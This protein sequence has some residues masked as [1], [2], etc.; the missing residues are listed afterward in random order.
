MSD[1][2]SPE[3]LSRTEPLAFYGYAHAAPGQHGALLDRM[4]E[5]GPPSR[6]EPGVLVYEIHQD[7]NKPESIAFYELY[8][9]G[10]ALRTHIEQPYMVAFFKDSESLL[11]A[12]LE[13]IP[14]DPIR[15]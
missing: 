11:R 13:I 1:I 6:N 15:V 3:L 12:D 10:A 9:D 14:L 4:L 8:A 7:A 5:L 2:V